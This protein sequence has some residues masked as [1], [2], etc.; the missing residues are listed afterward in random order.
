MP[1]KETCAMD[2]KAEFIRLWKSDRYTVTELSELFDVSRKTAYK[3]IRRHQLMGILGLENRS[4][5][6][7][8]H[9]NSTPQRIVDKVKSVRRKHKH[10]GPGTILAWLEEHDQEERWPSIS[11]VSNI[12]KKEGMVKARR[13][14]HKTP[15]HTSPFTKCNRPN[16][17]WSADYKGQFR[18]GNGKLCYPLTI[19]DSYS[20]YIILCKGLSKP[21]YRATRKCFEA[22]FKQ[23]GMPEAIKTDNGAPFASVGIYGLSKLSAWFIRLGIKHERI[24]P[25]HP[26]QNGRHERMH[27]LLKEVTANPP[28]N[29]MQSQQLAFDEFVYEYNFERPHGALNQKTP[30]T[31]YQK[32]EDKYPQRIPRIIYGFHLLKRKVN[33]NGEISWKERKI[34]ISK[35]LTGERIALKRKD[36]HLYEIRFTKYSIG[37]LD[38]LHKKVLPM[39]L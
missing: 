1:W 21:N 6:P 10:W 20:R 8:K 24:E 33:R 27:R 7:L 5:A 2:Q 25:G 29:N 37:I 34:F 36:E 28:K 26:E 32:S 4:R 39:C 14:R 31:S 30:A 18:M 23:Y 19:T 38:L 16:A 15:A 17:V 12:L 13:K 11:T 9:P 3:W 22:V 35:A